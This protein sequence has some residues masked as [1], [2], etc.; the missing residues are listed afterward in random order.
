M[1]AG[2][3]MQIAVGVVYQ[4]FIHDADTMSG[5]DS[6][7]LS[8]CKERF[9]NC[10]KLNGGVANISVFVDKYINRIRI[11]GMST[12]FIKHL[13]GQ[14]MLAG[15]FM[16]GFGVCK[17]IVEGRR[18]IDLIPF[19]I[20]SLFGIYLYLSVMSMVD[21]PSKRNALKTNLIDYLENT[22]ARRLE[23]GMVQ[24]EKLDE[25]AKS[26]VNNNTKEDT[27]FSPE[28]VL[29]LEEFIKTIIGN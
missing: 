24:K 23:Q 3:L 5:V 26:E 27:G 28:E 25:P 12:N 8:S 6:R 16:A 13:S 4:R 15:V 20:I 9:V 2:I 29:E 22:V 19:Y 1:A 14:I 7:L 18:F 17:G 21:M 10:Y 11:L